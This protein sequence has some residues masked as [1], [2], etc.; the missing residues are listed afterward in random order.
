MKL[1]N[2]DLISVFPIVRG[3][4]GAPWGDYQKPR[5]GQDGYL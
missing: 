2:F 1:L 5:A 4:G 3:A